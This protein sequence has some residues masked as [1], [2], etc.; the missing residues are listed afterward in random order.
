MLPAQARAKAAQRV[1]LQ[2]ATSGNMWQQVASMCDATNDNASTIRA[3]PS[4]RQRLRS[5]STQDGASC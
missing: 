3:R 5:V 1:H 4:Q 2:V